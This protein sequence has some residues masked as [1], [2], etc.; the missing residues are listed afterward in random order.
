MDENL[1]ADYLFGAIVLHN[2]AFAEI[3]AAASREADTAADW[4]LAT[5]PAGDLAHLPGYFA[6]KLR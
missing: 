2:W 1:Q 5:S 4:I 3:R 6:S